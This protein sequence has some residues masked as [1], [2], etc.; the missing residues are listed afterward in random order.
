[1]S[2]IKRDVKKKPPPRPEARFFLEIQ[3]TFGFSSLEKFGLLSMLVS[4]SAAGDRCARVRESGKQ[5]WRVRGNH[6]SIRGSWPLAISGF[7]RGHNVEWVTRCA[8]H[9]R[10]ISLADTPLEPSISRTRLTTSREN[11]KM[12]SL[13]H[14]RCSSCLPMQLLGVE[15]HSS[16][17]DR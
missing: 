11:P 6:G 2:S 3:P 1:M 17:P 16:L 15:T 9:T 14:R 10:P 4:F 8:R 5:I 13:L 12:E 7:P